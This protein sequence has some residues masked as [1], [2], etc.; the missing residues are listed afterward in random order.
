MDEPS[1]R[2]DATIVILHFFWLDAGVLTGIRSSIEPL[3]WPFW[4]C[5]RSS[6][7]PWGAASQP[8]GK[9]SNPALLRVCP[10]PDKSRKLSV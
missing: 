6:M 4:D 10:Q 3:Y 5:G 2:L 8:C 9:G 7:Q 1:T